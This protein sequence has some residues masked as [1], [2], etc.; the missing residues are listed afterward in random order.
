MKVQNIVYVAI[1]FLAMCMQP[2]NAADKADNMDLVR[3]VALGRNAT[4]ERLQEL[5]TIITQ[6]KEKMHE[7]RKQ[8]F[9][10]D[11]TQE[12]VR[13]NVKIIIE[14]NAIIGTT[15]H[16]LSIARQNIRDK[17]A[18]NGYVARFAAAVQS[19][20]SS[21]VETIKSVYDYSA[22]EKKNCT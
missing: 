21:I 7:A 9:V 15:K 18:E 19:A 12:D 8:L 22:D 20:G 11:A 2:V 6:A 5:E 16:D 1:S 4:T 3:A 14:Q 17:N 10:E 13:D